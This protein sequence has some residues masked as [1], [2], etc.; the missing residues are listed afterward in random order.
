[1]S[2]T[3]I[4]QNGTTGAE[5]KY[6]SKNHPN[7]TIATSGCGVCSS[8]MALMNLT[9]YKVSLKDWTALLLK[10][11][12]RALEGTDMSKVKD[13]LAGYG[14]TCETTTDDNKLTQHI[15]K[16]YGAIINVGAKGYFSSSGHFVYITG[17]KANGEFIVLDPYYYSNKWTITVNGI[18]RAKHFKYNA[19]DHTVN[20]RITSVKADRAGYYYLL[21]PTTKK[22]TTTTTPAPAVKYKD[23]KYI[24]SD[25]MVI[26]T[27]AGTNYGAK[28]VRDLTKDG[29]KHCTS[30]VLTATAILKKG[31]VV[32][33]NIIKVSSTQ[34]WLK[35]P[36]GYICLEKGG[37]VYA[38]KK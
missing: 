16:G 19:A 24:L 34:H 29:Q 36:S 9:T 38:K 27:G 26:R 18:N 2:Y 6:P 1:M 10:K 33:A 23:G 13:V 3:Y 35:V 5:I 8:L 17:I 7:A 22:K 21:T 30:K 32:S 37:K 4:Q 31:T 12:C 11:G 28:K 20:C 14:I 15:K 25:D